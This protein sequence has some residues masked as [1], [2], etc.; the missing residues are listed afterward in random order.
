[1]V[2]TRRRRRAERVAE[3]HRHARRSTIARWRCSPSM[4]AG[5][6]FEPL[7]AEGF[8]LRKT[9]AEQAE[10]M[11]T[12][13]HERRDA[14][15]QSQRDHRERI[16]ARGAP[17]GGADAATSSTSASSTSAA[18][19]RTSTRATRK[20]SWRICSRASARGSRDSP[21]R[22]D[23]RG[24]A[25]S[26]SCSRSSAARSARTART[27]PIT[28]TAACTGCSAARFRAAESP[29]SRSRCRRQTLNQNRDFPVLTEYRAMLGGV[30]K[31][32]YSL[33]RRAG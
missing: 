11:A 7:I 33:D 4:Y 3:R 27:A 1:M 13:R 19:T 17:H 5:T 2:M 6:R 24:T 16:R 8:D 20:G 12:R 23:R 14:G 18:G 30:F 25:R 21:S 9:V 10:M 28:A 29:A 22:W 15:G 31:R 32:M 26:S